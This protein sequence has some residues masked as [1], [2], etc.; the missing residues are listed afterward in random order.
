M[1]RQHIETNLDH[2][3]L[4]QEKDAENMAPEV[5]FGIHNDGKV[6]DVYNDKPNPPRPEPGSCCPLQDVE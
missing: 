1:W 2:P 6:I 4:H 3:H 5:A